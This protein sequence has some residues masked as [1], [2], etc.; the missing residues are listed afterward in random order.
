[1]YMTSKAADFCY[2]SMGEDKWEEESWREGELASQVPQIPPSKH[3]TPKGQTPKQSNSEHG[4]DHLV[5]KLLSVVG[6]F[7]P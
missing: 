3:E 6:I 5:L 7:D 1:M 4:M 2:S